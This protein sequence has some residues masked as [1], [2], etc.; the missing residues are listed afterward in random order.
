MKS[1]S[2]IACI[3]ALLSLPATAVGAQERAAA[4]EAPKAWAEFATLLHERY[5]YFARSGVDGERILAAFADRARTAPDDKA[6]INVLQH[7]A[8]N[9]A[10]P[11]FVVGPLDSEDWSIV[12]TASDLFGRYDG[13]NFVISDVRENGDA[14]GQGVRPGMT[15]VRVEGLT[16]RAAVEDVTGRRFAELSALQIDFA[17]NVAL[18]GHRKRARTLELADGGRQRRFALTAS[19]DLAQRIEDGPLLTVERHGRIGVIR[20]NNSL[21]D[22]KLIA[23]F[24]AALAGLS[25]T[26]T[27][28][29]DLRNTPSGGNTSVARGIMGHFVDHDRPYQMHVVPFE[30]RVL[31]PTRKFVEYVAPFGTRYPG[32]VYVAGGR[33]TGSMGEGLMIGFDAIGATTVGSVLA[34]LLGALDNATIEGSGATIDLGTEQLFTV[35]GLPRESYRPT[36]YLDHAERTAQGDPVLA[37]IAR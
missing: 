9:F 6:F 13:G 21:G 23:A 8:H 12:P 36:L 33:W 17:F 29:I 28:L 30:T 27:L 26:D 22:Q 25:D 7:V 3:A 11:H 18:A 32:K 2:L 1:P 10:D 14:A 19:N 20:I 37:A 34:H 15:V 24:G 16:P 35:T 4:F 31:G 5:G